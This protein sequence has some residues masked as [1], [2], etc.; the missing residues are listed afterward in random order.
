MTSKEEVIAAIN[1]AIETSIIGERGDPR[2][3]VI[4]YLT[5]QGLDPALAEACVKDAQWC[6][7]GD[8]TYTMVL[9]QPVTR[10]FGEFS[11]DAPLGS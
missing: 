5:A 7:N 1:R 9:P 11:V 8:L 3:V 6:A 2:A 4:A 10:L